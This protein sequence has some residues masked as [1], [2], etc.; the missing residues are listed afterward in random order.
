MQSFLKYKIK[1]V[2]NDEVKII[3]VGGDV[4]SEINLSTKMSN[5][6]SRITCR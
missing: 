4:E 2:I 3:R 1:V 5:V 6:L